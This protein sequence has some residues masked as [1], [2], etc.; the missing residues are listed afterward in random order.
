MVER[1]FRFGGFFGQGAFERQETDWLHGLEKRSDYHKKFTGVILSRLTP[2]SDQSVIIRL[3]QETI[4]N[5]N[6]KNKTYT[7]MKISK[8]SAQ[9]VENAGEKTEDEP[10]QEKSRVKIIKNE[11]NVKNTGEAKRI[12]GFACVHYTV[13]WN[14]VTEDLESGTINDSLLTVELWNTPQTKA[15]EQLI[16]DERTF[17]QAYLRKLGLTMSPAEQKQFGISMIAGL[18]DQSMN[19]VKL[20]MDRIGGYSIVTDMKWEQG[21]KEKENSGKSG[22]D[23]SGDAQDVMGSLMR[24]AKESALPSDERRTIFTSYTEVKAISSA[25]IANDS[26]TVPADYKKE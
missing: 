26:F 25:P 21:K 22:L 10:T 5:L 11:F 18:S 13:T 9:S 23:F 17:N 20:K 14:L 24:K 4:Q 8:E 7:E 19:N 2:E 12:N 15:F 16:R 6:H 3:K 1:V